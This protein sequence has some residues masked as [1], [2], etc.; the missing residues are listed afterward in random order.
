MAEA[1]VTAPAAAPAM[2]VARNIH[3]RYGSVEVLK[4]INLEVA[5]GKVVC[6]I[7]ASGAGKSTFLRCLN[8]LEKPDL[9]YVLV[10]S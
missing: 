9:G 7:G 3:K 10:R 2:V 5:A 4:G 8:H 6:I 1:S